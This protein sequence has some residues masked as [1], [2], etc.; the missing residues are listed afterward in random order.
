MA[1]SSDAPPNSVGRQQRQALSLA[2]VAR[3][4]NEKVPP[5]KGSDLA[6]VEPLG[7]C[8][9]ARI[10]HLQAQGRIGGQQLSHPLVV[11]RSRLDDAKLV[12]RDRSAEVGR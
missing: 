12:F 2:Q 3:R 7:E 10:D 1:S 5:V 11:I 8:Y 4:D 6:H 9:H